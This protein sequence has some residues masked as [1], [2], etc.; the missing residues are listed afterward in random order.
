MNLVCVKKWQQPKTT[1]GMVILWQSGELYSEAL[2]EGACE[3]RLQQFA[4]QIQYPLYLQKFLLHWIGGVVVQSKKALEI[5][6]GDG[7]G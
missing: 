7:V 2:F 4:T 3:G 6:W 1:S 5:G